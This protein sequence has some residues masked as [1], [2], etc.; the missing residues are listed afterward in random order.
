MARTPATID[1][2]SLVSSVLRL[3]EPPGLQLDARDAYTF[4]TT[5]C[6]MPGWSCFVLSELLGIG[7]PT[8]ASGNR[9]SKST[10]QGLMGKAKEHWR[11]GDWRETMS[12][13]DEHAAAFPWSLQ[14][15]E[16]GERRR[17]RKALP[18]KGKKHYGY[19]N[20]CSQSSKST[21]L[22]KSVLSK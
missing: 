15:K 8:V 20:L 4:A 12:K 19:S 21:T 11:G 2:I 17:V 10:R 1:G 7:G 3:L 13:A 9:P 6:R 22:H 14:R 5:M 18:A 16:G